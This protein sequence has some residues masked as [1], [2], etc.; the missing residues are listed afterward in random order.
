MGLDQGEL[1]EV[2]AIK[3]KATQQTANVPKATVAEWEQNDLVERYNRGEMKVMIESI[4][5]RG[6][7]LYGTTRVTVRSQG[8]TQLVDAFPNP[9]C[10]FGTNSMIVDATYIKC[11]KKPKSFYEREGDDREKNETCVQCDTS[12]PKEEPQIIDLQV[13]L[14]G[15]FDDVYSSLPYRY[16]RPLKIEGIYPR[17]GPKDGDTVV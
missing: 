12:P 15:K 11:S 2:E 5:P 4:F 16:Y 10:K 8:L 3:K 14:T 1:N 7:P 13:S 17:Y 9:K 6:G